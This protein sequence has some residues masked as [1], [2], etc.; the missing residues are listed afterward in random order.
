MGL[1]LFLGLPRR[2]ASQPWTSMRKNRL[3]LDARGVHLGY[4][5]LLDL[6]Q[7]TLSLPAV[8][9]GISGWYA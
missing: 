3:A 8:D 2:R 4:R 5:L 9:K 1:Q 7:L 6:D